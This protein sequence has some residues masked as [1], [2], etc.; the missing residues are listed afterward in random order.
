MVCPFCRQP[1]VRG[2]LP[3]R[4]DARLG[5]AEIVILTNEVEEAEMNRAV[6]E[7]ASLA[8]IT[9]DV[10]RIRVAGLN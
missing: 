10:A 8:E 6:E 3:V 4:K 2:Y 5:D 9:S 7:L 1:V